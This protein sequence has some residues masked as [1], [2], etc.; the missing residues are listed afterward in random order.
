L[1]D[2]QGLADGMYMIHI[3]NDKGLNYSQPVRKN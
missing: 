2:M 3:T 1:L